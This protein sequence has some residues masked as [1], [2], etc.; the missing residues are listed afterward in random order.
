MYLHLSLQKIYCIILT[1]FIFN[2]LLFAQHVTVSNEA[3]NVFHLGIDN[4]VSVTVENCPCNQLRIKATNGTITGS[5]CEYTFR[6]RS[7]GRVQ[8]LVYR[9]VDKNLKKLQ[10]L[11]FRVKPI[12]DPS[13]KIGP[14]GFNAKADSRVIAAQEY[15][16]AE[17]S[18]EYGCGTIP[19]KN[20]TVSILYTDSCKI[21]VFQ[22]STGKLSDEIR[23][24]FKKIKKGDIII[25]RGINVMLLDGT[26]SE[27]SPLLPEAEK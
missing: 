1:L 8:I 11:N 24:A 12:P 6:P 23:E 4:P 25:F 16:R 27:I 3:E 15:V 2:P 22:N 5:N 7:I 17:L 26:I 10:S 19:I 14:Y 18:G 20:F 9:K 21:Q 13:F